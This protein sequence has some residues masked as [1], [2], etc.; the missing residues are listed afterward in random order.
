MK[1]LPEHQASPT[2]HLALI[3]SVQEGDIP[4]AISE[5]GR[6][7]KRSFNVHLGWVHEERQGHEE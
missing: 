5:E 4:L 2:T 7:Q 3:L 1:P 6:K